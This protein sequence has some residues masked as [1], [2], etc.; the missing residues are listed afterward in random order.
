VNSFSTYRKINLVAI[1][2]LE[3]VRG[4]SF[5]SPKRNFAN[6]FLLN[7]RG[8]LS[9]ALAGG[10]FSVF[11]AWT[12]TSFDTKYSVVIP[13]FKGG[14]KGKVMAGGCSHQLKELTK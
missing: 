6:Q 9:H 10:C 12:R 1:P 5:A 14:V 4:R 13:P 2:L 8:A 11:Q 3:G 7:K